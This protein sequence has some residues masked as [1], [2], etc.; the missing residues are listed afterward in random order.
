MRK[1][2]II[3]VATLLATVACTS[4]KSEYAAADGKMLAVHDER[5][6]KWM[7]TDSNGREPVEDYDSMRV[8]ELGDDGHPKTVCYYK[9][10]HQIWLQYYSQMSLRSRGEM[11]DGQREGPWVFYF[12]N[13]KVQVEATF[14]GGREDGNYRVYRDNGVPIYIGTYRNGARTGT[15]EVYDEEGNLVEKKKYD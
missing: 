5:G 1:L 13:G 11:I 2:L 10:N 7:I 4:K 14:V 6:D 3:I 8:T 15:W 12:P 9:G